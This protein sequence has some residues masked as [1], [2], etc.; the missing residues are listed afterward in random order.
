MLKRRRTEQDELLT[1]RSFPQ[2]STAKRRV[3]SPG[4]ATVGNGAQEGLQA[5]PEQREDA[6][7]E[8]EEQEGAPAPLPPARRTGRRSVPSAER[9][10]EPSPA[11]RARHKR[12][13]GS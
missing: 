11:A 7:R 9:L 4:S 2:P 12:R 3:V 5:P 10:A 6:F 13:Q 8:P 1:E